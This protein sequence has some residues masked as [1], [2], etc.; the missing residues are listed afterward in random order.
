MAFCTFRFIEYKVISLDTIAAIYQTL[1][2]IPVF[3]TTVLIF[4]LK[5]TI[6]GFFIQ[7]PYAFS[8]TNTG[9]VVS[10]ILY[11]YQTLIGV[12]LN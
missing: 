11:F 7:I 2:Y 10:N 4:S 5:K 9:S 6:F 1:M 8:P 12:V 3:N